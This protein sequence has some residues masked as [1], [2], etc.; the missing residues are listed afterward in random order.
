MAKMSH[1]H[2]LICDYLDNVVHLVDDQQGKIRASV[3]VPGNPVSICMLRSD[4]AAVS[5]G[6]FKAVQ[7]LT[8]KYDNLTLGDRLRLNGCIR[9]ISAF[10]DEQLAVSFLEP[11]AV[12]MISDHGKVINKID[13]T[14]AGTEIFILPTYLTVSPNRSFIFVSDRGTKQ[15]IM[16][17]SS[18]QLLMAFSDTKLLNIPYGITMWNEM[19]LVC[20]WESNNIVQLDPTNG[21]MSVVLE[22]KDGVYRP[23]ALAFCPHT[24]TLYVSHWNM[25]FIQRYR[26][27]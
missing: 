27:K 23:R 8:L 26:L 6:D 15:I 17:T 18:L 2:L 21:H 7:Y 22:K 11:P 16:L 25:A 14:S 1:H 3:K 9:G 20:G 19:V 13:N 10:N 4:R 24:G 5:L 12:K